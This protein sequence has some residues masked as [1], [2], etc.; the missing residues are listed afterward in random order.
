MA[1]PNL[2]PP[3][4]SS[5]RDDVSVEMRRCRALFR[6]RRDSATSRASR[7]RGCH[8]TVNGSRHT[9]Q[10]P[11]IAPTTMNGSRPLATSSGSGASGDSCDRSSSQAK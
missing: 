8:R 5:S 11:A 2:P 10:P 3:R 1:R 6:E 7:L 4:Q 9:D